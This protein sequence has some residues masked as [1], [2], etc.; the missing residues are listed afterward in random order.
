MR[1]VAALVVASGP[2]YLVERGP[3]EQERQPHGRENQQIFHE[4]GVLQAPIE[5]D[6]ARPVK[7]A[8]N[9][10]DHRQPEREVNTF[11][12]LEG[13]VPMRAFRSAPPHAPCSGRGADCRERHDS[14]D[15]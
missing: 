4:D 6:D 9:D 1:H 14:G 2:L 5:L 13:H 12:P 15:A 10:C 7:R 11:Q 8:E 3:G